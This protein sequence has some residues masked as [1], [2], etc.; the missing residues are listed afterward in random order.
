MPGGPDLSTVM[1][2]SG[3]AAN[4]N[5]GAHSSPA[6]AF[7]MTVFNARLGWWIGNPRG[8]DWQHSDPRSGLAYLIYD[9]LGRTST[10]QDFVCLSDGGHFDNMG[11]Y[12]LIRRRVRLIVL[13]RWGTG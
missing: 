10:A 6:T 1:A 8:Q 11:L 7:L 4:P 3:A 13:G 9:L 12:E 5:Q 2:I